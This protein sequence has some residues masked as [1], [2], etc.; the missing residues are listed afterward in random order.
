MVKMAMAAWDEI[1][2]Y[3][4]NNSI[5]FKWSSYIC[6]LCPAL[7]AC[8]DVHVCA[9]CVC[10]CVCMH[11]HAQCVCMCVCVCVFITILISYINFVL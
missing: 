11:M 10:L 4:A 6:Y 2:N 8:M 5:L 3:T 1:L 9:V 7:C